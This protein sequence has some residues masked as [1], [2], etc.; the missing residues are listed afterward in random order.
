MQKNAADHTN[1]KEMNKIP[2]SQLI[3]VVTYGSPGDSLMPAWKDK[4]SS[5]E[6]QSVVSYVRL[7]SSF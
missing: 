5:A 3:Q 6:I 1:S 7:L 2:N 4:L